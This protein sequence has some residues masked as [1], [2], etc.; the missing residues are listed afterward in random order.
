MNK[1]AGTRLPVV[2][3]LSAC[4]MLVP[5]AHALDA[6]MARIKKSGTIV[7]GHRD[8][9][10]PFSYVDAGVVKGYSIDLCM[11][12]ADAVRRDLGAKE[13]KVKW[14]PVNAQDR[15]AAVKSGKVDI[16]CGVTTNTLGRQKEVDFSPMTFVDGAN[17]LVRNESSIR[18]VLDL[19]G[20]SVAVAGN[21]TTE[22]AL[23]IEIERQD[24]V[25]MLAKKN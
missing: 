1:N 5:S 3:A 16:E 24:G 2:V 13:I 25:L 10:V 23:K 21:T 8:A 22:S 6:T 12:V 19:A 17:I 9:A 7:M 11:A 4:L 15:F 14:V 18:S 20:K